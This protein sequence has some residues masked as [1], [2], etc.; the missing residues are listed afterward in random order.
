MKKL[1]FNVEILTA[2]VEDTMKNQTLSNVCLTS[3]CLLAYAG[4]LHFD[5]LH[6]L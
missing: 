1:P 2:M 4:F 5:E 3:A 6:K